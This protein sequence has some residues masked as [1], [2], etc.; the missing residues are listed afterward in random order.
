LHERQK[1]Q[2]GNV[3]HEIFKQ[4]NELRHEV[5]RLRDEVNELRKK[6]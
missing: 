5:G 4:L 6:Q 3:I 2:G 1:H